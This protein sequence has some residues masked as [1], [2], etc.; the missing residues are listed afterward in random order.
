MVKFF[1][2]LQLKCLESPGSLK[3]SI[4]IPCFCGHMALQSQ[5]TSVSLGPYTR[6]KKGPTFQMGQ[7]EFCCISSHF[8]RFYTQETECF[9]Q[10]TSK[11]YVLSFTVTYQKV[12]SDKVLP[13]VLN[14]S[15]KI[16]EHHP[17]VYIH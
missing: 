7:G 1:L 2:S 6:S 3:Y 13:Q 4:L 10:A 17:Q 15:R 5:G 9:L 14:Q 16:L 12:V 11:Y 8:K